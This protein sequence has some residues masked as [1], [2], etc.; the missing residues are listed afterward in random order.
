MVLDKTHI[1]KLSYLDVW[2][3]IFVVFSTR[4]TVKKLNVCVLYSVGYSQPNGSSATAKTLVDQSRPVIY[5]WEQ[6]PDAS[7]M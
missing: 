6:R 2:I 5:G 3:I 7:S 4:I 1:V